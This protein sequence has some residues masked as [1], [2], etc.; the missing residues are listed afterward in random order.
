MAAWPCVCDAECEFG[1]V[2]P[3][4]LSWPG[5]VRAWVAAEVLDVDEM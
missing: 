3:G 2:A 4:M 5:A 1:A